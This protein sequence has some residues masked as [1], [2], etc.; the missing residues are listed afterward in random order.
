MTARTLSPLRARGTVRAAW[1]AM[2]VAV[3]A[4]ALPASAQTW[5]ARPVTLVV[6]T[7]AGG[8]IDV[9]AR[10]L[11]LHLG[12]VTG[13]NFLV[14]NRAGA[15]GSIASEFVARAPAEVVAQVR[16][17]LRLAAQPLTG[18]QDAELAVLRGR[19]DRIQPLARAA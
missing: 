12:K 1:T 19:L 8:A 5:P 16:Q 2:A 6:G 13:G 9:Y 15:N 18:V 4:I 11:A 3:L 14:D 10:A 7:P 17:V